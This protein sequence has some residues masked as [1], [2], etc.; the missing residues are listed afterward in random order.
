MTSSLLSLSFRRSDVQIESPGIALK[1]KGLT[2]KPGCERQVYDV[3][4][5]ELENAGSLYLPRRKWEE[6]DLARREQWLRVELIR[7][8]ERLQAE[9]DA[10]L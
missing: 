2:T 1:S 10:D 6:M 9:R 3:L 5:S 8:R 7:L 4:K